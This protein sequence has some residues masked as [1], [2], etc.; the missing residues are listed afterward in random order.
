MKKSSHK[1]TVPESQQTV[2]SQINS[3]LDKV[4]N[5]EEILTLLAK[6]DAQQTM[7][8]HRLQCLEGHALMLDLQH[9]L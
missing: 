6:P 3:N 1:E 8:H 9:I 2:I 4:I 5:S 7:K